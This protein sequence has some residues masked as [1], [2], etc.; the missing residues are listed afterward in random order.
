MSLIGAITTVLAPPGV[1]GR[2]PSF[3]GRTHMLRGDSTRRKR[4]A[5]GFACSPPYLFCIAERCLPPPA[6]AF[7]MNTVVFSKFCHHLGL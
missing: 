7:A 5:Y 4:R 6:Y 3:V 2:R 1:T